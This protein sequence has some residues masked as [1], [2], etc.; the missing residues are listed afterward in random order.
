[1]NIEE[2]YDL[3]YKDNPELLT[4]VITHSECVAR[5]A[6]GC[7]HN[8]GIEAD[9]Q[10]VKEAAMLHDIGV[11]KCHAPG[12]FC[13]GTLPYICHGVE[14]RRIL[15]SL[16]Y[17][18]H[19][20]VCDS[21]TGSGLTR[22]DIVRQGLPLPVRD[23]CPVSIEEKVICYA[24]KFFSKSGNLKEEKSFEKVVNQMKKFGDDSL[25]RFLELHSLFSL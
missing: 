17:P 23:L 18:R 6:L 7:L 21:H 3:Y 5:K 10:F 13:Y 19:A 20:L 2:I 11:V 9:L 4:T 16:G 25:N 12:I 1:M 14:G 24:D 22:E 8:K 15:E